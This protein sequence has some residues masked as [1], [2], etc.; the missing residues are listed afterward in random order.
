MVE[1]DNPLVDEDVLKTIQLIVLVIMIGVLLLNILMSKSIQDVWA[2]LS[3]QQ[4]TIHMILLTVS[5][6]V[7]SNIFKYNSIISE[8][9]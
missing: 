5:T 2:L 6:T 8:S 9:A 3:A 1:D 7:P 4:I